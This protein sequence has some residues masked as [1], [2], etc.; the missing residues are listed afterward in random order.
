MAAVDSNKKI[1][2]FAH[3]GPVAGE[4]DEPDIQTLMIDKKDNQ[5]GCHPVQ[6]Y[7]IAAQPN[8]MSAIPVQQM[9]VKELSHKF[10]N[11]GFTSCYFKATSQQRSLCT[12]AK[13]LPSPQKKDA[14]ATDTKSNA[15]KDDKKATEDFFYF[16]WELNRN[17]WCELDQQDEFKHKDG[18]NHVINFL[19][20]DDS[21]DVLF[22]FT[23][24]QK[25]DAYAAK[26]MSELEGVKTRGNTGNFDEKGKTVN[27]EFRELLQGNFTLP[28][29]FLSEQLNPEWARFV[30]GSEEETFLHVVTASPCL[31]P[32]PDVEA[33][34]GLD[35]NISIMND[36]D[37][38]IDD[39]D[40]K[41]SHTSF[42]ATSDKSAQSGVSKAA[43]DASGK[44][45]RSSTMTMSTRVSAARSAGM[46]S[47]ISLS[48]IPSG[49]YS[50][51]SR[52]DALNN[53]VRPSGPPSDP[54][55]DQYLRDQTKS[56]A[57][58]MF[59][60]FYVL[61]INSN[62][63]L[64][65][66]TLERLSSPVNLDKIRRIML[67]INYGLRRTILE[68]LSDNFG[69]CLKLMVVLE[70]ACVPA[71]VGE[72]SVLRALT[73]YE[74]VAKMLEEI[75]VAFADLIASRDDNTKVK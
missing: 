28:P 54:D 53:Q 66:H 45:S 52:V 16:R 10:Y 14:S 19:A 22:P 23:I 17:V 63:A 3:G 75:F 8:L 58:A 72:E 2:A 33:D 30:N 74:I 11:L 20:R 51:T 38:A 60:L 61:L 35:E 73:M 56:T 44:S 57:A 21:N 70:Q 41:S 42:S 46:K 71:A 47:V 39:D 32:L 55:E 65:A 18:I 31:D 27:S 37:A 64:R 43:T 67:S 59:R 36:G 1:V 50:I 13:W 26:L 48:S 4:T 15:L 5:D 68:P 29:N 6:V 24:Q 9:L 49:A 12:P 7:G 69:S 62:A 40:I 25:I 34:E